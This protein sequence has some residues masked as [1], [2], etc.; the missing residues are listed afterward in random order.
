MED[1]SVSFEINYRAS[2]GD[3]PFHGAHSRESSLELDFDWVFH[4]DKKLNL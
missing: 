2:F 3:D 4:E 1:P